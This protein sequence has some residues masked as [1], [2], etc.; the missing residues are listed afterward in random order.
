MTNMDSA[1]SSYIIAKI[2]DLDKSKR[3]LEGNLR[4]AVLQKNNA[5]TLQDMEDEIYNNI[6]YLLDSF[7]SIEY[8]A[9]NELVRKIV[10]KC[11]LEDKIL[12]IIF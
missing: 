4:Q 9:K 7:D 5:K 8:N 3:A 10:K 11:I 1:A 2:E 12:R 6:C